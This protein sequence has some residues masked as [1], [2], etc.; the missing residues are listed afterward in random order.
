MRTSNL[1][2]DRGASAAAVIIVIAVLLAGGTG[3]W[4]LW[5][6]KQAE[7][8]QERVT[9]A[10]TFAADTLLPAVHTGTATPVLVCVEPTALDL[11]RVSGTNISFY[12]T[13][14]CTAG[15]WSAVHPSA[16]GRGWAVLTTGT[17][18]EDVRMWGVIE[19]ADRWCFAAITDDGA[20]TA[21]ATPDGVGVGATC[22]PMPAAAGNTPFTVTQ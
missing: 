14:R 21:H 20:Y 18:S 16:D 3:L 1:R 9:N 5:N 6:T 7:H 13:A 22:P 8:A 2:C 12:D 4:W 10:V 15:Q 19:S 11:A 17:S